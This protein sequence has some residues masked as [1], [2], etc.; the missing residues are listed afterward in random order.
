MKILLIE[1][2]INIGESLKESLE[3]NGY[4]LIVKPSL[5]LAKKYL[6]DNK[7]NLIILD[8]SL[9]DGNGFDFYF[10]SL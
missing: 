7:P 9:P 8:I 6:E 1:D 10:N 3:K 2:N 4:E 5:S